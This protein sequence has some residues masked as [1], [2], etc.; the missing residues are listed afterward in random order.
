MRILITGGA[1]FIGSHTAEAFTAAGHEVTAVDNL[2]DYYSKELK[3]H[4][5]ESLK[6]REVNFIEADL[7]EVDLEKLVSG[8]DYV[9]HF[10]AQPGISSAVPFSAYEK[11]NIL[12]THRLVEA[13]ANAEDVKL[14]VNIST[15]SVY[16]T[17][18]TGSE[19]AEP[20]PTSFYGVTKLA[21]EQLVLSYYRDRGVPVTS[22]R[23]FSVYGPRERP[24]KLYTKLI[25]S[26]VNGEE[27]PLYEG[28]RDHVRSFTYV[29]DVVDGFEKV[30]E[31]PAKCHGEIFNV[32]TNKTATTG[33][34]I[35]II[36]DILGKKAKIKTVPK[37]PGDQMQTEASIEKIKDT[38]GWQPQTELSDGLKS[39][40]EWFKD[41]DIQKLI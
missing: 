15:S 21:A 35:D 6:K 29:G 17:Q 3:E 11:N 25:K 23:L 9:F 34:G 33:E 18:A 12:A 37:R 16:G 30:L 13:V 4:T 20:Q 28:S 1:G 38:L 26:I 32:G 27:F 8:V 7:L 24:E 5:A 41:N 10:A 40:V 36:E 2:S 14:F 39:Q 31:N 22:L 19:E